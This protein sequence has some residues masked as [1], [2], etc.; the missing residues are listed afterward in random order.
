ML[1]VVELLESANKNLEMTS[2]KQ[3]TLSQSNSD[4]SCVLNH[5]FFLPE[6]RLS[7]ERRAASCCSDPCFQLFLWYDQKYFPQLTEIKF[8]PKGFLTL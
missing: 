8:K 1:C 5:F 3:Q 4:H 2:K 7:L 6:G